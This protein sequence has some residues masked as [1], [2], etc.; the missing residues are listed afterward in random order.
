MCVCVCYVVLYIVGTVG[1]GCSNKRIEA[2]RKLL[3]AQLAIIVGVHLFQHLVGSAAQVCQLIR[4]VTHRGA[5]ILYTHTNTHTVC[6]TSYTR[7]QSTKA[8]T[9]LRLPNA[10]L[11]K[12]L[13]QLVSIQVAITILV[14]LAENL[15]Q[16]SA[17]HTKDT[18]QSKPG[19]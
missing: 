13:K 18:K 10:R 3:E 17:Q 7:T 14:K 9:H 6:H 11:H 4:V 5:C 19:E 1:L 16:A 15:P 2:S 12:R 8:R